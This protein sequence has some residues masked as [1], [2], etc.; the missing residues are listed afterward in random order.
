[1]A[2][3][4]PREQDHSIK[5][6]KHELFEKQ[7]ASGPRRPFT[8]YLEQTPPAPLSQAQKALLWTIGVMVLLVFFIA[9]LTMPSHHHHTGADAQKTQPQSATS[10]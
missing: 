6:R 10:K 9:M 8:E 1:M 5:A 4:M 7:T 3:E 2:P